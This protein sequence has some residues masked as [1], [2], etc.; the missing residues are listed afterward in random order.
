MPLN[1]IF[2]Y[3]FNDKN[4]KK[5]NVINNNKNN[6]DISQKNIINKKLEEQNVINDDRIQEEINNYII[7]V[8][9]V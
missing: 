8:Y 1:S 4:I 7:Y 2:K 6:L 5:N 9:S 3:I